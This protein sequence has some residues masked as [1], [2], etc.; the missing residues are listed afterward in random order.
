M[1]DGVE[2]PPV[3]GAVMRNV[4]RHRGDAVS[5]VADAIAEEVPVAFIYNERSH[6]VMMTTPADL[7]DFALGFSLTEGIIG[8]AAEYAGVQV[9]QVLAGIE[10]R[11]DIPA[12]RAARLEE[13]V[14]E[15]TGRTGCGL[16]GAQTLEAAVRHP[17][18]VAE[19]APIAAPALR[20]ALAELH[21]R[22]TINVATGATHAAAWAAPD[23][24]IVCVRED[25]GR[26]NALDK[27]VGAM[28][29]GG[30][31]PR[32]GFLLVTSRASFEIVMKAA[33][34]GIGIVAAISAPTA[35]AIALAQ[36]TNVTLIGFARPGGYSVYAHSRRIE[37]PAPANT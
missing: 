24:D 35:L 10:L 15:L 14:R 26:H 22:Q 33:T 8:S 25:V 36:E 28:S 18:A 5:Q 19:P 4:E 20:R 13:R 29:R 7:E 17:A 34:V 9:V 23:G 6:A 30:I 2:S 31:D 1:S 12:A 37:N 21:E 3:A 32:R 11:I 27:L 16:C